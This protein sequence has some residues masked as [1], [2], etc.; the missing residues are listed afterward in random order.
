MKYC[1]ACGHTTAGEPRFCN[2]CGRSYDAKLCPSFHVNP[3]FAEACSHCGSRELSTPQPKVPLWWHL[4]GLLVYLLAGVL[5]TDISIPVLLDLMKD[6][7]IG[8]G[9]HNRGIVRGFFL[10][11]L[12]SFWTILPDFFRQI[13]RRSL[14]RRK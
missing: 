11:I 6:L 5:L 2:F 4:A 12:W 9:V 14:N 8:S 7:L 10:S 1:Y 3:R 13:V